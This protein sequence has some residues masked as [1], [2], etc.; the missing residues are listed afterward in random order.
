MDSNYNDSTGADGSQDE[1]TKLRLENQALQLFLREHLNRFVSVQAEDGDKVSST[2]RV[3]PAK[4][5]AV[6]L[7][8]MVQHQTT[9]QSDCR[10]ADKGKGVHIATPEV[11]VVP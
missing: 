4:R 5:N 6:P 8:P 2:R 9:A 3:L 10:I 1:I 7:A 11:H